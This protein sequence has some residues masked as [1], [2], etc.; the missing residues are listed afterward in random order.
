M[1]YL[2][3][4]IQV[5]LSIKDYQKLKK[6]ADSEYMPISSFVRIKVIQHIKEK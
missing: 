6:L 2:D 5:M 4:K 1:R 3:K